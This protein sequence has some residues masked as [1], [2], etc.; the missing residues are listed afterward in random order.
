MCGV[1]S[2]PGDL[3]AVLLVCG[4]GPWD[5]WGVCRNCDLNKSLYFHLG[6]GSLVIQLKLFF[7]FFLFAAVN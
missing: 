1:I 6:M 5:V 2:L 4:V 7:F 3:S